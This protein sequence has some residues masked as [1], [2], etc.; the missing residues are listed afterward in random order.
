[1]RINWGVG[2]AIAYIVFA[3]GMILFAVKAS[4]QHYDLVNNDY[5]DEA[6]NYQKK[7]DA[8]NNAA[9]NTKVII[10][11]SA[12]T[13]ILQITAEGNKS[14]SGSI[15]FYK[16]DNASSDFKLDFRTDT[17]GRQALPLKKLVQGYWNLEASYMLNGNDC[18][19]E[20]R[21]FVSK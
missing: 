3:S 2:I 20:K 1:M 16:P 14:I 17:S 15:S 13:N 11:Y 6:V 19:L 8:K 5:Y 9:N 4:Q 10:D 18:S 21:I 12:A 7:I